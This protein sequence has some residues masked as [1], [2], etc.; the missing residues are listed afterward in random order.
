[1]SEP[2]PPPQ[3]LAYHTPTIKP[4]VARVAMAALI[5]GLL[6]FIP[7]ACIAAIVLGWVGLKRTQDSGVRGRGLAITGLVLGIVWLVLSVASIPAIIQARRAARQIQCASNLR[8][9]GMVLMMYA[10]SNSG[11][12]PPD[13]PTG[14]AA[15]GVTSTQLFVCSESTDTPARNMGTVN[16][17]K[18]LSY[19]YLGA[20]KQ[21]M[22][23][24][25]AA[26]VVLVYETAQHHRG[27]VN[28]LFADGHVELLS[29]AVYNQLVA[30][31]AA[32]KTPPVV[33]P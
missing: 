6:G 27:G 7:L 21:L 12:L 22:S 26:G 5:V 32:G 18:H 4:P 30:D 29:P 15:V 11:F 8:Q 9:I 2:I 20:G 33:S 25:N 17:G 31:V 23:L 10:N 1:M 16:S 24:Q 13:L 14:A 28:A 19:I 3:P